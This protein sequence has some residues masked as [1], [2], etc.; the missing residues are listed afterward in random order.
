[1]RRAFQRHAEEVLARELRRAPRDQRPRIRAVC[2]QVATAIVEGV[3]EDARHEPRL[4]A[5]LASIYDSETRIAAWP[6]EAVRRA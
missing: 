5:A 2:E 6:V 3:L 1:M 4:A